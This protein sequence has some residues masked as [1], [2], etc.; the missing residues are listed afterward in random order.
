[1]TLKR[2]AVAL[3]LI[4]FLAVGGAFAGSALAEDFVSVETENGEQGFLYDTPDKPVASLILFAGGHGWLNLS[5]TD[6]AW[7]STN[8]VVRTR[9]MFVAQGFQVAVVDTPSYKKKINAKFR[10]SGEHWTDI[11]AVA[12]WLRKKADVP[13][14][15]V[16]TSMGTFSSANAAIRGAGIIDGL[17]MTSS[18]TRSAES[19]NIYGDYPSGVID[20]DLG[21]V[22]VPVLVMSH[23]ND[24]CD[25]T[26]AAD[27]EKL[28]AAFSGAPKA[29]VKFLDGGWPAKSSPCNALSEHGYY[30]IEDQAVRAVTAFIKASLK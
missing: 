1:M 18:I 24:G 5:G 10:M 13:V 30:G 8:F 3:G 15:A 21:G 20:M 26:P 22:T 2:V 28:A 4:A 14:W 23:K 9:D 25:K 7:G 11:R 6:M 19:W 12:Q 16:G 29:D 17:V 27:A